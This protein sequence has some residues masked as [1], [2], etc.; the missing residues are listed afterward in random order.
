MWD[1]E[2]ARVDDAIDAVAR[3]ITTGAPGADMRARVLAR[4]DA[5][6]ARK[7]R[8]GIVWMV[9]AAVAILLVVAV[10]VSRRA[11]HPTLVPPNQTAQQ[12]TPQEPRATKIEP[13]VEQVHADAKTSRRVKAPLEGEHSTSVVVSLAPAPLTVQQL[14]VAPM[15]SVRSIELSEMTVPPIE[16][17]PLATD[18][19]P[20]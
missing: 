5:A 11:G 17:A 6:A 7:T 1:D 8:R 9:P 15:E 3:E 2:T 16:V 20:R 14:G 18:D 13:R 12:T 19:R 4:I 10:G